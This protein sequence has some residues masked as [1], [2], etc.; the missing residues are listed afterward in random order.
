MNSTISSTTRIKSNKLFFIPCDLP[1]QILSHLF[2][3]KL[4]HST[5]EKA[6]LFLELKMH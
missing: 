4:F 5:E 3:Y 2:L 1:F 6:N